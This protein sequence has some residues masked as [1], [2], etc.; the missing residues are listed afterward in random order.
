MIDDSQLSFSLLPSLDDGNEQ[1]PGRRI[2]GLPAADICFPFGDVF[3]HPL[4]DEVIVEP[5]TIA[6]S[7]MIPHMT[8]RLAPSGSKPSCVVLAKGLP[9]GLAP[10]PATGRIVPLRSIS[11]DG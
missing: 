1:K 2:E 4:I 7:A 5:S 8:L 9:V 10:R 11:N 6:P 3:L